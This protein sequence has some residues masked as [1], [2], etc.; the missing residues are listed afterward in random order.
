MNYCRLEHMR[1]P[2]S[3]RDSRLVTI[4]TVLLV[5]YFLACFVCNYPEEMSLR[6]FVT[7]VILKHSRK[8][9]FIAFCMKYHSHKSQQLSSHLF[10]EIKILLSESSVFT[11]F[12]LLLVLFYFV[13]AV[14]FLLFIN[15]KNKLSVTCSI[16]F[17]LHCFFL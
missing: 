13:I 17:L 15:L 9:T 7:A 2:S 11:S 16:S 8:Y 12:P 3:S 5:V 6:T 4:L 10:E 1:T 14:R